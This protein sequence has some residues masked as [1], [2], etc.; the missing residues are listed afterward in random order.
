MSEK[1]LHDLSNLAIRLNSIIDL[2][3]EEKKI[4]IE[5]KKDFEKTIEKLIISW[6]NLS[7][8]N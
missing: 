2:T 3:R 7:K 8:E 5:V 4:S 1:A 6:S